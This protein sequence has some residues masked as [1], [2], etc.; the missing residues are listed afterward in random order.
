MGTW[1]KIDLSS[2][3]DKLDRI[4]ID[5]GSSFMEGGDTSLFRSAS[6]KIGRVSEPLLPWAPMPDPQELASQV[7]A[8]ITSNVTQFAASYLAAKTAELMQ[9]PSLS[10]IMGEAA[11]MVSSYL[12]TTE[13]LMKTATGD[14]KD[15]IAE[16]TTLMTSHAVDE[17]SGTINKG[18]GDLNNKVSEAMGPA[19][20]AAEA[21]G[22]VISQGPKYVMG[23]A[24][25]INDSACEEIEKIIAQQADSMIAHKKQIMSS[26]AIGEAKKKASEENNKAEKEIRKTFTKVA[27]VKQKA[28]NI[29]T[30]VIKESL[31]DMK[32]SLGL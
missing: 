15:T 27:Q 19:N 1:S 10:D 13:E 25:T 26:L 12:M 2:I 30:S 20:K 17:L 29:V 6:V 5:P 7:T 31:M 22:R 16:A 23:A 21:I 4:A 9:P 28:K 11:E 18:L 32:A 8:I 14:V 24:S 3:K